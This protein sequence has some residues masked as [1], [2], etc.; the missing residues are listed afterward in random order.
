MK[1]LKVNSKFI[2]SFGAILA[3][4]LIAVVVAGLGITTARS[5]Y[6]RFYE[7]EFEAVNKVKDIRYNQQSAMKELML[8]VLAASPEESAKRVSSS[9]QYMTEVKDDLQWLYSNYTGD[10]TLLKQFEST[11]S[12]NTNTRLQ[13]G[14]YASES[15]EESNAMATELLLTEY[16][17]RIEECGQILETAVSN[18]TQSSHDRYDS[19]M[20]MLNIFFAVAII[21]SVVAFV[22]TLA[23][24]LTLTAN[25]LAPVRKI[26]AA[27]KE[28]VKGN[29][30]VEVDYESNDEFGSM[31]RS[32]HEVTS[33]VGYI[34]KDIE[35]I[36][37]AMAGGDFAAQS[38]DRSRYIGD[39]QKILQAMRGIK[40]SLNSTMTTLNQSAEQVSSGSDQ[41]SSGAQ[42]L[43]QGA[44]EQASSVEELAASI[45]EISGHI[46]RNAES[47]NEASDKAGEVGEEAGESNRR[48]QDMLS[49]MSDISNSSDEIGKII[50]TIEDIAFQT[51]ILALNAAVEA[52]RAGAAGKGF[53]VVADEVR[54][55][56]AKSAD[57]SKNTAVL[58]ENSLHAVDNGKKIADETA[59][60]L[61]K[62]MDGI[63]EATSMMDSI[64]KAS[65]EQAE[66]I[67]QITV[68]IDQISSVVQTNSA[69]A[70]ESAAASE[71]L[72]SQAQILK[73]LVRK[74]KLEGD[75]SAPVMVSAPARSSHRESSYASADDM[76]MSMSYG[77]EKY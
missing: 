2:V 37:T 48:M 36:L 68:G 66:A 31:A 71:E 67:T 42:A 58:I 49:A 20:V 65:K 35:T 64:A 46:N 24:A 52:A 25:I 15:T 27:M 28:V 22:I 43:S 8:G 18:M 17:P 51:N 73:D 30:S 6:R 63:H 74:F 59:K 7:E 41:V 12:E 47:A 40:S 50:K 23:I 55:L 21:V 5:S 72:S 26:E 1:N 3:L 14:E 70:E 34:I 9:N 29:L 16:T 77:G 13:V 39:Y 38:S 61:E 44:T 57:A 75:S 19:A 45:N 60:S 54:N 69:T 62:V 11:M 4:F 76:Q 53:A 10:L 32:M 33:G 56:A